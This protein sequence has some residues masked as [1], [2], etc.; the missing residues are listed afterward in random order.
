MER[1]VFMKDGREIRVENSANGKCK[2]YTFEESAPVQVS[3]ALAEYAASK[4]QGEYT[5]EDYLALPDDQRVELIDGV[6]YDMASPNYIHQAFGDSLQAVFNDYIRNN[7]GSCRAFTPVDVQLDCDDR[8]VVQPDV[9]IICDYSKLQKGQVYGAPDLVVE[10]LSPSTSKKDRT[11]KLTKYKKAGVREYWIIDPMHKRVFVYEFEKGD[12][13]RI[14]SFED[15]VPV[16]IYGGDC[17]VDFAQ[18]YE[19]IRFLYNTM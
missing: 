12:G 19:E 13:Y 5:L 8:T 18:I 15:S 3:E 2:G 6:F 16:G 7:H 17:V 1:I 4:H 9:L 14:Y 10:V 11:L